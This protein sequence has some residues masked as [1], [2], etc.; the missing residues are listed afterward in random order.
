MMFRT[1]DIREPVAVSFETFRASDAPGMCIGPE[2][3]TFRNKCH[4]V[5]INLGKLSVL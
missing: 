2:D 4:T 1:R 3:L 5:C